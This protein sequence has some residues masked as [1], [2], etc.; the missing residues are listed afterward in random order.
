[1]NEQGVVHRD[2]KPDNILVTPDMKLKIIDFGLSWFATKKEKVKRG[3]TPG[4]LAPEI[5]DSKENLTD[6]FGLSS[7]LYAIGVVYYCL[8][9]GEHPFDADDCKEVLKNN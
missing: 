1:M 6:L 9:A 2:L 3:G 5:L 7:D 8:V 4:F